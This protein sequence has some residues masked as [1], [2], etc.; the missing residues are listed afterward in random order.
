MRTP[1]RGLLIALGACALLLAALPAEAR[2]K[3]KA[4]AP[5]AKPETSFADRVAKLERRDGLVPFYLDHEAGKVWLELP[6][7]VDGDG[8][9]VGDYLY[10]EGLVTGLGSNPVGLDRGQLGGQ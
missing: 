4:A 2:K 9:V 1:G 10:V 5:E 8:G 3:K 6:A 7:P